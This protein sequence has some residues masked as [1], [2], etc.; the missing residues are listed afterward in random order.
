M[1]WY[2][3]S[4]Q[5]LGEKWA[6]WL[7]RGRNE[8]L[9]VPPRK[10]QRPKPNSTATKAASSLDIARATQEWPKPNCRPTT[11]ITAAREQ[12]ACEPS[13]LPNAL[14]PSSSIL[15]IPYHLSPTYQASAI[16]TRPDCC[17]CSDPDQNIPSA[18]IPSPKWSAKNPDAPC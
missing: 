11:I 17:N 15:K 8:W 18:F 12:L 2:T 3:V 5:S 9:S 6:G 16:V 4:S 13:R 10:A 14:S 1:W 7:S